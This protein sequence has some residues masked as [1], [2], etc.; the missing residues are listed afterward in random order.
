MS[1]NYRGNN[2]DH[3][4]RDYERSRDKNNHWRR[5][6]NNEDRNDNWKSRNRG[7]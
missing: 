7:N 6:R 2:W 3:R 1:G 5:D 4:G